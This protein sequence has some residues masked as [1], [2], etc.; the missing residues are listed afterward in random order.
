MTPKHWTTNLNNTIGTIPNNEIIKTI[1][2]S[3]LDL[4]ITNDWRGACHESCGAIHILLNETGIQNTWCIGEAKIE[5]VFFDHSW[6]EIN[7]EI[8]DISVCK[9]LEPS[10]DNGSVIR[11]KD[12]NT[13]KLTTVLYNQVSGHPDNP[14]TT[15]V[16][17][18][19]LSDYLLNSPIDPFQGTWMLIDKV[20]TEKL[21]IN[22]DI[23]SLISKYHGKYYTIRP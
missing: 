4:T 15:L 13:N 11:G 8:Y 6:I 7:S 22:F 21:K 20:A 19:N 18:I 16:K 9:S 14:M 10:L 5:E 2:S 23:N 3:I 1:F 12:I 17:N